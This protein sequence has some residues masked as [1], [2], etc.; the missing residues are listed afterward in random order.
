MASNS[1]PACS[2]GPAGLE[3]VAALAGRYHVSPDVLA[4]LAQRPDVITGELKIW[5]L[6]ATIQA[7]RLV[8]PEQG[9]VA[10]GRCVGLGKQVRVRMAP[11]TGDNGID[12]DKTSG[13]GEGADATV[14]AVDNAAQGVTDLV[15]GNE[16]CRVLVAD[17][18]QRHS[19]N[20]GP[21]YL[22]L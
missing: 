11:V 17:P 8:P 19:G 13:A 10:Q 5:K 2:G 18:L 1:I 3:V 22:L 7:Q 9:L 14:D 12:V 16:A 21:Q 4:A 6:F 20:I 15:Q